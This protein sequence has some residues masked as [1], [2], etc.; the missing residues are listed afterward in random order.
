MK[1][2]HRI[3]GGVAWIT[4]RGYGGVPVMEA[5][6][7]V[8]DLG[9]VSV[10]RGTWYAQPAKAPPGKFYAFCK[11][12][13]PVTQKMRTRSMHRM[14]AGEPVAANGTPLEVHHKDNDGLNNVRENL[15]GGIT[16]R[17]NMRERWPDQD[18]F[19][20]DAE[21]EAERKRIGIFKKLVAIS[22]DIEKDFEITRQQLWKIR[23]GPCQS[24]AAQEYWRRVAWAMP[25]LFSPGQRQYPWLC[26]YEVTRRY[27]IAKPKAA[28]A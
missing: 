12:W 13:N 9:L 2:R 6:I 14:I 11:D 10:M 15:V 24:E 4:L 18:W 28:G 16:H 21:D 27:T 3:E 23:N 7:D 20:R 5:R 22:R 17:E 19:V 25:D 1:N 26:G 8:G